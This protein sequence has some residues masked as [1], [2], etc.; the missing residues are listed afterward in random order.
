MTLRV[1]RLNDAGLLEAGGM[2]RTQDN[3]GISLRLEKQATLES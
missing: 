1:R 2:V 3:A